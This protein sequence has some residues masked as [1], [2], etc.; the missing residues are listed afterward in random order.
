MVIQLHSGLLERVASGEPLAVTLEALVGALAEA[1]APVARA[2]RVVDAAGATLAGRAEAG[3]APW[4]TPIAATSG[5]ALGAI[6]VYPE[7][8]RSPAALE[9]EV[10][11]GFSHVA[12]IAIHRD[13]LDEQLRELSARIDAAREEERIGIA[14]ELHDQLGQSL[15]VLKIDLSAIAR[16][17]RAGTGP[18]PEVLLDR[19]AAVIK[20]ADESI[21][22]LRRISA[23]LRPAM[24]DQLGLGAALA[25]HAEEFAARTQLKCVVDYRLEDRPID[26][27]LALALF[28]VCQEALTNVARHAAANRVEVS[29]TES[30]TAIVLE[31]RDDGRGITAT[32]MENP[33]SFGLVGMR[34]RARRLG[35]SVALQRGEPHGTVLTLTVPVVGASA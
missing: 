27:A 32:E 35:G 33:R 12:G 31:V 19:L 4:T 5:R 3:G 26:R 7:S 20:M 14:R 6:E 34:E 18:G 1:L 2:V 11:A 23:E 29:V 28:R 25:G 17:L 24:L 16:G 21:D 9:L 13:E 15:T 8:K 30:P 22:E 10:L